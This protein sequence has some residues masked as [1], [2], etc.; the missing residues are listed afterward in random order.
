[1]KRLSVA[2]ILFFGGLGSSFVNGAD[3]NVNGNVDAASPSLRR[4][5]VL[6]GT[7]CITACVDG[8]T[9]CFESTSN[10][11]C[12][13]CNGHSACYGSSGGIADISCND[14]LACGHSTGEI[15]A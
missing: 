2:A 5:R 8:I 10:I 14:Q 12:V 7:Q 6:A 15:D 13:S 4:K 9:P 11:D 1:M 3:D